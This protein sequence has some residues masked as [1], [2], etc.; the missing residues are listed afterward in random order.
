MDQTIGGLELILVDDGS[1]DGSASICLEYAETDSRVRLMKNSG[2]RH[3]VSVARNIG[4]DAAREEYLAFVDHDDLIDPDMYGI[5]VDAATKTDADLV[6]CGYKVIS[7]TGDEL[8]MFKDSHPRDTALSRTYILSEVVP[9]MVGA[10]SR[11]GRFIGNT[12]WK[13]VFRRNLLVEHHIRFDESRM[14]CED[15]R[16][17]VATLAVANSIAFVDRPMYKWIRYGDALLTRYNPDEAYAVI[18][19]QARYE[20]LFSEEIDFSA[21]EVFR[22]RVNAVVDVIWSIESGGAGSYRER[23]AKELEMLS[24]AAVVMWFAGYPRSWRHLPISMA[25]RSTARGRNRLGLLFL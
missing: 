19:N 10:D 15:R 12:V 5:M 22:Y 25:A 20:E 6:D 8:S 7:H 9:A 18:S 4:I 1:S 14:K 24:S 21:P 2:V 17:V 13:K 3:G 11:P 23:F 16:F